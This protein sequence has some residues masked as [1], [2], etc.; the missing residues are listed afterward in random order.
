MSARAVLRHNGHRLQATAHGLL[1]AVVLG[2]LLF[3]AVKILL[4]FTDSKIGGLQREIQPATF[5]FA[6][7]VY[8]IGHSFRSLRLA[9]LIGGW[10]VGLRLIVSFHFMTA[11]VSL[12]V[13]LKLGE[14]YRVAELSKI[15]GSLVSAIETIWWERLFDILAIVIIM[16]VALFG[17]SQAEWQQFVGVGVLAVIFIAVTALAFF[18]LPDNLRRLSVLIIRRYDSR[19]S[20]AVLRYI[21]RIRRAIQGAPRMVKGKIA[22]IA[23]LTMLIWASELTCFAIVLRAL[24]ESLLAAPDALLSFLSVLTRG[25]TL[26]GALNGEP[27]LSNSAIVLYLAATQI[28]LVFIGIIATLYYMRRQIKRPL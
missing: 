27:A 8:I 28:P 9:L 18:V 24:G 1:L 23:A 5:I 12:A 20:V 2:S 13:P 11:A 21:E 15:L 16:F 3:L 17:A 14:I 25:Y 26:L 7:T 19:R 22:S 6:G 4:A 10:R